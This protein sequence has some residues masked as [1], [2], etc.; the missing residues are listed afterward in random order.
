MSQYLH[1]LVQNRILNEEWRKS[2]DSFFR[3]RKKLLKVASIQCWQNCLNSKCKFLGQSLKNKIFR[4]KC[5]ILITTFWKWMRQIHCISFKKLENNIIIYDLSK[6]RYFLFFIFYFN[7]SDC[8]IILVLRY[9]F[10]FI[11]IYYRDSNS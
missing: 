3:K 10:S 4:K 11:S 7:F 2:E 6:L 5:F 1:V 9:S 8:H